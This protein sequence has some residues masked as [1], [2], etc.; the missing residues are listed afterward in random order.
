MEVP[1]VVF[2]VASGEALRSG[3][4][5]EEMLELQAGVGERVLRGNALNVAGNRSNVL[6]DAWIIREAVI[7]G[8]CTTPFGIPDTTPFSISRLTAVVAGANAAIT[9]NIPFSVNF[10]MKDRTRVPLTA[11]QTLI[12][13]LTVMAFVSACHDRFAVLEDEI[14]AATSMAELLAIDVESGWPTV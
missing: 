1:Y 9:L 6:D 8:G 11:E 3:N 13:G 5:P 7:A 2:N 14:N 10:T 4:I 12:M